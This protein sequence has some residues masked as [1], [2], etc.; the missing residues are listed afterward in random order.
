M[1]LTSSVWDSG[2]CCQWGDD[3]EQPWSGTKAWLKALPGL[4]SSVKPHRIYR[5]SCAFCWTMSGLVG[6]WETSQ[7]GIYTSVP[8]GRYKCAINQLQMNTGS[9][10]SPWVHGLLS[11]LPSLR[12]G[13]YWETNIADVPAVGWRM[14]YHSDSMWGAQ[15][16]GDGCNSG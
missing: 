2:N 1:L 5:Q 8:A 3:G 6:I 7:T 9:L 16:W 15:S 13:L 11:L 14:F 10:A 4:S 12:K